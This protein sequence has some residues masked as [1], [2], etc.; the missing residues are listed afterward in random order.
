MRFFDVLDFIRRLDNLSRLEQKH[1][2]AIEQLQIEVDAPKARVTRPEAR[3]G[4]VVAE[5]K[6]AAGAASS[7]AESVFLTDIAGRVGYLEALSGQ[8]RDGS[9]N[10]TRLS[11]P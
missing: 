11:P 3:E 7:M 6:A 10:P 9:G 8:A 1:D 5:A 2:K 4:I